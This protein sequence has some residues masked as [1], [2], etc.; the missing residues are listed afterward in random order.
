MGTIVSMV[1]I[2]MFIFP[3]IKEI[4]IGK[5]KGGFDRRKRQGEGFT[6]IRKVFVLLVCISVVLNYYL[7]VRVFDLGRKNLELTKQVK[8]KENAPVVYPTNKPQP[9]QPTKSPDV[10]NKPVPDRPKKQPDTNTDLL[11]DLHEINQIQ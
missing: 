2:I 5:D 1:K 11:N 3:F 8:E 9:Q 6:F 7:F 4:V 10:V